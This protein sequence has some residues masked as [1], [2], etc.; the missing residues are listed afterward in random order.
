MKNL[1]KEICNQ[2]EVKF[3]HKLLHQLYNQCDIQTK[4]MVLSHVKIELFQ[5]LYRNLKTQID[6][7]LK[8]N[9]K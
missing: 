6:W 1:N 4:D 3:R 9:L 7:L 5:Q 8:K 2:F